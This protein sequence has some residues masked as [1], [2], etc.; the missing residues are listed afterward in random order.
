MLAP[1]PFGN[2][3]IL[4]QTSHPGI[5]G[6]QSRSKKTYACTGRYTGELAGARWPLTGSRAIAKSCPRLQCRRLS[7]L[8]VLDNGTHQTPS[9]IALPKLTEADEGT[10]VEDSSRL[11]GP[12]Q[13]LWQFGTVYFCLQILDCC[14]GTSFKLP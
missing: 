10:Y 8:G 12:S 14:S 13:L 3:K 1:P 7:I 9:L 4:P 11:K 6:Y 5:T 2:P